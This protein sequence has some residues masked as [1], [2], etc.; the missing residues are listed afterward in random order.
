MPAGSDPGMVGLPRQYRPLG[1]RLASWLFGSLFVVVCAGMWFG[2]GEE[3]RGTFKFRYEVTMLAFVAALL[4]C[5][6]ALMRCRVDATFDGLTIVNGY[7]THHLEWSQVVGIE[8]RPGAP[9]V[10]FDLA[11]GN[12]LSALGIQGSDGDRAHRQVREL[13]ALIDSTQ[14]PEPTT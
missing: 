7:R 8:L 12:T 5:L 2:L 1:V 14:P 11:D 6:H 3:L 13:R 4:V 10:S 9:W